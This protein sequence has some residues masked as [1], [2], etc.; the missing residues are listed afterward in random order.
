MDKHKKGKDE[1][2]A[3]SVTDGKDHVAGIKSLHVMLLQDDGGW[4][5]QGLEVDYAS[6]GKT[7]DEA[8]D[9]F[10]NGLVLTVCEHLTMHGNLDKVLVVAPQEAWEEYFKTPPD[11]IEKQALSFVTS[12]NVFTQ[13]GATDPLKKAKAFPFSGVQFV[14]STHHTPAYC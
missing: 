10:A 7:I 1:T 5:A 11:K 2:E 4:F 3:F 8:K 13:A 9:N 6:C 14:K 12:V